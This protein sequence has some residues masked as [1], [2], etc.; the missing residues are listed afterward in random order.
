[1]QGKLH[2]VKGTLKVKAGQIINSPNREAEGEVEKTAGKMQQTD[3][4]DQ[5]SIGALD[6]P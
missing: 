3:R 4:P 2:E 1:M 6:L 5:R